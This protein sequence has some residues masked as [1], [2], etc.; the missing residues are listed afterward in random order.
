M[1]YNLFIYYISDL[2]VRLH[3]YKIYVYDD[4]RS[5]NFIIDNIFHDF[6]FLIKY[7]AQYKLFIIQK[8][9]LI[10]IFILLR[11]FDK[12]QSHRSNY[13]DTPGSYNLFILR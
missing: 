3:I 9:H 6:M 8:M 13:T 11:F 1:A 10:R 5:I 7:R 12:S 4:D 2:L